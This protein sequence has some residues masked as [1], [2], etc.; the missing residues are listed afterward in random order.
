LSPALVTTTRSP[1]ARLPVLSAV[2]ALLVAVMVVAS[3]YG[4]H[5]DELY[6]RL[7][8]PRWGYTDQPPLTPAVV[9]LFS[10]L[11][12]DQ[13]WA[14]RIPAALLG[15]A[16]VLVIA[17]I[18]REL[19]GGR[20]GQGLAAWG[21]AFG[22]LTLTFSHL[23]LTASWDLLFWPAVLL[24]VIRVVRRDEPRWWLLAGA[25]VGVSTFNKW[26]VVILVVAVLLGLA[27]AGPRRA[28]RTWW[29]P[30]AAALAVVV[31]LPNLVWQVRHGLPQLAVGA[32]L[33][34]DNASDVRTSIW[35]LLL[36]MVGPLI[37]WVWILGII[38][39]VRDPA[40]REMRFLLVTFVAVLLLSV[41]AGSQIYYPYPALA[42][43][44]TVGCVALERTLDRPGHGTARRVVLA[45]FALSVLSNILIN[46][47]VIGVRTVGGTPIVGVNQSVGDT[48]GW[49]RY[50]TQV[51][52]V[53]LAARQQD[54]EVVVLASNYGE[55]GALNRFS[56]V[57]G[58][59][60]VSAHNALW[61]L[62]PPPPSTRTV[63]VVGG[64]YD[65]LTPL[66]GS[67]TIQARLDDGVGVDNEEQGEPVAICRE[68]N[69]DWA[70]LWPKL[71]HLG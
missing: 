47:P 49:P 33:S 8:P 63:V 14:I 62:G 37:C 26:L 65:Q 3:R 69:L 38:R 60:L 57:P 70:T 45:V 17:A 42:V 30:L 51:D 2:V 44:F 52:T 54:P 41:A 55:A 66:F 7:L 36:I 71:R 4:Y 29:L 34:A 22:T 46:L 64:Q 59:R 1:F 68:P 35:P 9:H 13:V 31:A 6:F 20:L 56:Q 43:L 48:V 12:A 27:L 24:A 53:V 5:R 50:V 21:F 15:A 11:V 58:L 61:D 28:L 32:A 25:L 23:M 40:W 67:C 19:G 39:L 10:G 18:G 16:G